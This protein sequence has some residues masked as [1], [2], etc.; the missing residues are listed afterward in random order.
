MEQ[1][2]KKG[3]LKGY[4]LTV[5]ILAAAILGV[6]CGLIFKADMAKISFIGTLFLRLVQMPIILLVMC[7]VIEATGT[8]RPNEL[9]RIGV[10]TV[11]WFVFSTVL[12]A[13]LGIV[14]AF[15]FQPGAGLDVSGFDTSNVGNAADLPVVS[16]FTDQILGYFSTNIFASMS[17]G[18]TIQCTIIAI[19]F[20]IAISIY[21]NKHKANPVLNGVKA[22]NEIVMTYLNIVIKLLPLAIFSFVSRAV[23][24]VGVK[25]LLTLAKL[26]GAAFA[27]MVIMSVVYGV[28]TA[29]YVG[30]NPLKM[31]PKL[32]RTIIVCI[33]TSSS[34]VA[35]PIKI[36]DG[37]KKLGI[38]PRVNRFVEPM[39]VALNTDGGVLYLTLSALCVAQIWSIE[40]SASAMIN[41][42]M[43]ATMYSFIS[44]AVP[45]GGVVIFE[46]MLASVGFP[47]EGMVIVAAADFFL[48]PIRTVNNSID[49]MF[50]AMLVAKSENEF[51]KEI[52]NGTKKFD[53]NVFSYNPDYAASVKE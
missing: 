34:A 46:I 31:F 14:L 21:G 53:P 49:D 27:G 23:G 20:G 6:V 28:F 16:G 40:I 29:V 48:G 37:E 51:S 30:V 33:T 7:A 45:G 43:M 25:M 18:N 47:L 24:V 36:E 17:A 26:I 4:N 12:A 5:G 11:L 3:F 8:L 42:V 15:V 9:G 52:Y 35:L 44:L 19:L 41:L 50:V 10:K 2:N 39:G 22:I 38:S 32:M 13:L 1:S